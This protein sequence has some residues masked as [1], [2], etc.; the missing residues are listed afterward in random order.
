LEVA[1][2]VNNTDIKLGVD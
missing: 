2:C 1:K